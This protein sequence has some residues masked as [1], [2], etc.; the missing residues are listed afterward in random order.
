[1]ELGGEGWGGP[2]MLKTT[3][4]RRVSRVPD[5]TYGSYRYEHGVMRK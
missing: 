3:A 2:L 4:A 1:M 5:H